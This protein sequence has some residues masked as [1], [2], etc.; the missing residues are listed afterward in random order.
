MDVLQ[1]SKT[2]TQ[3]NYMDGGELGNQETVKAGAPFTA[4]DLVAAM[5]QSTIKGERR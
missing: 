3:T 2:A 1:M 5:S 4:D